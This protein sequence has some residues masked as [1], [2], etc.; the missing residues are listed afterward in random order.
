MPWR[1]AMHAAQTPLASKVVK[2]GP[3][4]GCVKGTLKNL[5]EFASASQKF[6]TC[7][8]GALLLQS[9]PVQSVTSGSK[10]KASALTPVCAV[11]GYLATMCPSLASRSSAH[12]LVGADGPGGASAAGVR[13]RPVQTSWMSST[14]L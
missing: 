2:G 8:G 13:E 12:E 11:R 5:G 14:L 9:V 7:G 10:V 6:A 1:P 3:D 4:T